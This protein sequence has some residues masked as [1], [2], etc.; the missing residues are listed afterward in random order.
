MFSSRTVEF[1][2]LLLSQVYIY[3]V[4]VYTSLEHFVRYNEFSLHV[5]QNLSFFIFIDN[6]LLKMCQNLI[7]VFL[8]LTFQSQGLLDTKPD[9]PLDVLLALNQAPQNTS[10]VKLAPK[11]ASKLN[12]PH[13][14]TDVVNVV[15]C[16]DEKTLGG[17]IATVNSIWLNSKAHVKFHVVVDKVSQ[18]HLR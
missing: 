15:V 1:S 18:L 16:S 10:Q 12:K 7:F 3:I 4:C 11:H 2:E 13:P 5:C 6:T 9:A 17:L 14:G 8:F